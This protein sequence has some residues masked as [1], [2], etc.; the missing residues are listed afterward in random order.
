MKIEHLSFLGWPNC[1]R[2]SN[3]Q[4][5]VIVTAEVGPRVLRC[6]FVGAPNFFGVS[7]SLQGQTGGEAWKPYG[8]HRLW[9]APESHPRT[10]APDNAPVQ[11]ETLA[12]SLRFTQPTEA[13]TGIQKEIEVRLVGPT[14][15]EVVHRLRNHNLWPVNLAP[16]ALTV[17]A[18]NGT[19]ILPLPPRRPWG[20]D[21]LL[22]ANQLVLWS[23]TNFT[24]PRWTFGERYIL[25]RQDPNLPIAQKIGVSAPIRW[26]AYAHHGELFIKTFA[27]DAGATYPDF[28]SVFETF[29]NDEILELETLG[30]LA[31][32]AP[33]STVEHT[34]Y[35]H[36]FRNV[37]QPT[38]ERD[39]VE[40]VEPLLRTIL[41]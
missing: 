5:E 38:T 37:P 21:N 28:G 2:I 31:P 30:P 26:A 6:G 4:I 16:W 13:A 41:A 19:A 29:T 9:H 10:Y 18:Q 17:M 20:V 15:V 24:D 33:Q 8:G 35:W 14:Q 23:Y 39:V 27:A 22:P 3:E 1:W 32:L 40:H 12:N 36:L 25:L 11:V 34:E 7:E